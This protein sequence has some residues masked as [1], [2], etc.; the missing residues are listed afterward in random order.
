MRRVIVLLLPI[1]KCRCLFV[2]FFGRRRFGNR[3]MGCASDVLSLVRIP[4]PISWIWHGQS[5]NYETSPL[6]EESSICSLIFVTVYIR[7]FV[8][9][10]IMQIVSERSVMP[11][12][13][14][15]INQRRRRRRGSESVYAVPSKGIVNTQ[16][17][18]SHA[19]ALRFLGSRR[20]TCFLLQLLR[21]CLLLLSRQFLFFSSILL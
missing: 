20:F 7:V 10:Y 8:L 13:I 4:Y 3:C 5:S 2:C 6:K 17:P 21:C 1:V 15:H 19:A 18:S 12:R 16:Y 14:E 9:L 11:I